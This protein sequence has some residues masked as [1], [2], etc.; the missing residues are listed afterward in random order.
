LTDFGTRDHYVAAMKGV[1][2]GICPEA[3]LVDITHDIPPQDIT[4]AAGE[5]AACYRFFPSGTIFLV[6]IDP[7]VGS[8]RRAVAAAAGGYFFVGPDNG[9][10]DVVVRDRRSVD[11]V[12]LTEPQYALP[13]I[14]RTFEG[15]DRFAPAAGW[16]AMGVPLASF[17]PPAGPLTALPAVEVRVTDTIIEGEVARI[18]R[19]GNVVTTIER[20]HLEPWG[21][22]TFIIRVAGREIRD[23]CATYADAPPGELC[24]LFGS[25]GHL[26]VAINGGS[27][28]HALNVGRGVRGPGARGRLVQ[29]IRTA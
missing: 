23:L 13:T 4:A 20:E 15:R 18:D 11:A 19:F 17:G 2:L 28:A 16:L 5:I 3:R 8:A 26:E 22:A 29:L 1:V 10:F 6:V 14:S 7:G 12:V 9:V 24:A 25:S 27:A 21:G